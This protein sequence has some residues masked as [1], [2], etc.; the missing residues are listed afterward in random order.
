[1]PYEFPTVIF[2]IN[3]AN[4]CSDCRTCEYDNFISPTTVPFLIFCSVSLEEGACYGQEHLYGNF[5]RENIVRN[6][7]KTW[8][9]IRFR[10]IIL[11]CKYYHFILN[12]AVHSLNCSCFC[13]LHVIFLHTFY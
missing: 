1:M 9:E 12:Y 7:K 13:N 6:M 2:A 3:I 8:G 11:D 10:Q 5:N 4:S